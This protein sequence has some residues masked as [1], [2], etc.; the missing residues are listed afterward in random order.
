VNAAKQHSTE[1]KLPLNDVSTISNGPICV[2]PQLCTG[3][4]VSRTEPTR[5]SSNLSAACS[6]SL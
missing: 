1:V 5:L 6:E 3:Y 4:A 2:N